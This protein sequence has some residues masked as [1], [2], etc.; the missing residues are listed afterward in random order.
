MEFEK[1]T[2]ATDAQIALAETP[3]LTV[4]PQHVNLKIDQAEHGF[5]QTPGSLTFE[6]ETTSALSP[7]TT[8]TNSHPHK[9]FAFAVAALSAC[10]FAGALTF[11]Y[12]NR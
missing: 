8:P 5:S 1:N 12:L 4:Q 3:R 9:L 2:P 11:A 6:V 10:L 7:A